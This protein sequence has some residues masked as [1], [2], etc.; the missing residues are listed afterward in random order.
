MIKLNIPY[1]DRG[2]I[3][4]ELQKF[5][6][7]Q[8]NTLIDI[9]T[10]PKQGTEIQILSRINNFI[11]LEILLCVTKCLNRLGFKKLY[12]YCPSMIGARSDRQFQEGGTSYLVDV[13]AP[14]LNA[15][16]FESITVLDVHSNVAPACINNLKMIDNEALVKFAFENIPSMN[17]SMYKMNMENIVLVSPDAGASHK[18]VKLAEKIG[19]KGDIITCSKERDN[20]GKLTRT[21]VPLECNSRGDIGE[22]LGKD[23]ILID[24]ICD[25]GRTFINIAKSIIWRYEE[26]GFKKTDKLWPK[27]YLIVTHGIFSA[28]FN[29][30]LKYFDGIYCTNSY[31]D[32][33]LGNDKNLIASSKGPLHN[34][35]KQMN[36]F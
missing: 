33:E 19:Y 13:I 36:V 30:L 6:D 15:Q 32:L 26:N 22:A 11:D 9:K 17:T 4:F 35:I 20:D 28:G 29:E 27:I 21:H 18:I 16:N 25:G 34:V 1:Q 7:G 2:D 10:L 5:P 14:I 12:L 24:D 23:I 31:S 8:N 3:K